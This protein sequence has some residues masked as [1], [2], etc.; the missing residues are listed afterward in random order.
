MNAVA[1]HDVTQ[2]LQKVAE[3]EQGAADE[4]FQAVYAELHALARRYFRGERRDHTLQAT[5]LVHEAYVK[6]VKQEGAHWTNRSHFFAVA[7]CAMRQILVDHAL[8]RKRLKRGGDWHRTPLSQ[9]VLAASGR[10]LDLIDLDA[11]LQKLATLDERQARIVEL[12][13]FA[14]LTNKEVAEVLGVSLRAAEGDWSMAKAWLHRQM[15]G[16]TSK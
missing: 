11:A 13:F 12:R 15:N 7:A 8:R 9:V 1:P 10:S 2:I 6:L 4:L 14:G 5:A 16:N 3:G